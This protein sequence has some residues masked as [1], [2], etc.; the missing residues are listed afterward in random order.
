[1]FPLEYGVGIMK[2]QLPAIFTMFRKTPAFIGHSGLSGAFAFY[3]P[4]NN[5]YITVTVNQ[6]HK[7]GTSFKL[8]L[9][10]LSGLNLKN[11]KLI[12]DP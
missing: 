2:F 11:K 5:V 7:P 12:A 9:K 3:M 6:L 4:V 8:L 1:M 10:A